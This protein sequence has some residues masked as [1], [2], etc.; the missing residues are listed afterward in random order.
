MNAQIGGVTARSQLLRH[1]CQCASRRVPR[2]APRR[3]PGLSAG[4]CSGGP[5]AAP[6]HDAR[7]GLCIA[8]AAAGAGVRQAYYRRRHR[9]DSETLRWWFSTLR[10]LANHH[11]STMPVESVRRR[12]PAA[13]RPATR[14]RTVTEAA[15]AAQAASVRLLPGARPRR[16]PGLWSAD[17]D[18]LKISVQSVVSSYKLKIIIQIEVLHNSGL[19]VKGIIT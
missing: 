8:A 16:Y 14:T 7:A 4:R 18:N 12:V 10:P 17:S 19:P 11:S 6:D 9:L 2:R 13:G 1:L 5:A 3:R 15:A